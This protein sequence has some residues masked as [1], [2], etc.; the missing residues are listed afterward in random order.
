MK[1]KNAVGTSSLKCGGCDSW[2][3][4][5]ENHTNRK[6]GL[7]SVIGCYQRAEHGSHV[8]IGSLVYIVPLCP[9]CNGLH[10]QDVDIAGETLVVP[11]NLH[12]SCRRSGLLNI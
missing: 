12:A 7:C 10:G 5:W 9:S 4:H 8:I 3:D 1:V 6:A 11:P 2:L